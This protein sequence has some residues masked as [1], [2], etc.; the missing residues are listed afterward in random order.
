[1]RIDDQGFSRA[2]GRVRRGQRI[3]VQVACNLE[4]GAMT[5]AVSDVG[6]GGVV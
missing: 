2:V 5:H 1:M 4:M 6:A 3:K